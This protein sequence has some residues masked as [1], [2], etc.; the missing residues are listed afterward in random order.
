MDVDG[1]CIERTERAL[2]SS[3]TN[4]CR[5]T[6]RHI[7][8]KKKLFL[9]SLSFL[10]RIV[11]GSRTSPAKHCWQ[12]KKRRRGRKKERY[13]GIERKKGERRK[14]KKAESRPY[15]KACC[16]CYWWRCRSFLAPNREG[17][18]RKEERREASKKNMDQSK[19]RLKNLLPSLRKI[20][21]GLYL[22]RHWKTKTPA[23]SGG[24][25]AKLLL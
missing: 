20:Y 13:V 11:S 24:E 12:A 16:C 15:V 14:E 9:A 8:K 7:Y 1:Q 18:R 5:M 4:R 22:V 2:F 17:G 19:Q 23:V 21:S 10:R 3:N 25:S 6:Q